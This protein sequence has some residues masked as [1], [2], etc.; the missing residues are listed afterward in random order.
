MGCTKGLMMFD[1]CVLFSFLI[2]CVHMKDFE[3]NIPC[4]VRSNLKTTVALA[5]VCNDS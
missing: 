3:D 5:T 2:D 4:P 1:C